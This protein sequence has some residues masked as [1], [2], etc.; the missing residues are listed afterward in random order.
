MDARYLRPP[1]ALLCQIVPVALVGGWMDRC[2]VF[3]AR[4]LLCESFVHILHLCSER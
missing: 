3:C 2:W 4:A 1:I